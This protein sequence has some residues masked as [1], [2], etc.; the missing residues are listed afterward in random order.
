M[1]KIGFIGN[2]QTVSLCYFLQL[3]LKDN[4]HYSIK[5]CLYGDEFKIHLGPWSNKCN[6][7]LIKYTESIH[8]IQQC[9]IIIYQKIRKEKSPYLNEGNIFKN[10]KPTCKLIKIPYIYFDYS[11]YDTSLA[12]LCKREKEKQVTIYASKI[13]DANKDKILMIAI[14]HPNTFLFLE[15]LQEICRLISVDFFNDS[16]YKSLIQNNNIME[17]PST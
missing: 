5:W 1:Q 11:N 8:Y 15:V 6:N 2:C 3:L 16:Q 13:I 14:T 9:D 7:K 10:I 12:E 17:L 4:I